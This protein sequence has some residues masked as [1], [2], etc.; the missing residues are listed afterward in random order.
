M[1]D[2]Q[3]QHTAYLITQNSPKVLQEEQVNMVKEV[4]NRRHELLRSFQSVSLPFSNKENNK[5]KHK[6][7]EN[8]STQLQVQ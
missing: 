7:K 3:Y 2:T 5:E 6:L 8:V 1:R 4:D